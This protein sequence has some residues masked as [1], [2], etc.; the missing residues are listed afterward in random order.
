MNEIIEYLKNT[1]FPLGMICYGSYNDGTQNAESDFD[2]LL[3]C[4]EGK[5][6]HDTS[7]Y[8]GVRLDVFIYPVKDILKTENIDDFVQIHDGT[9]VVDEYGIAAGLKQRVQDYVAS[10]PP[11]APEEK[12]ELRSWCEKMLRRAERCDAEGLYRSHWLLT[13]SLTF[14]CDMRDMFYFG[15][16]KTILRMQKNDP[17]G[18]SLFC[19]AMTDATRLKNWIQYIFDEFQTVE[20]EERLSWN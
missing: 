3:I 13:D 8:N 17:H 10:I 2:A 14:Y 15:P 4:H 12:A 5:H 9:V 7:F 6:R 1:Y 11:K 20:K 18:F 19:D 16:K